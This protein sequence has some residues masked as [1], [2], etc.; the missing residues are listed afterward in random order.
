MC[1]EVCTASRFSP[2]LPYKP[3]PSGISESWWG[4]WLT[5]QNMRCFQTLFFF[6]PLFAVLVKV[7][8]CC[9]GCWTNHL[10]LNACTV[11]CPS[12]RERMRVVWENTLCIWLWHRYCRDASFIILRNFTWPMKFLL[13][14]GLGL[15]PVHNKSWLYSLITTQPLVV[16]DCDLLALT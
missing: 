13:I 1:L 7:A 11:V 16:P 15:F 2:P 4:G 14:T 9:A 6:P 3:W 10:P 5:G 8:A 12:A